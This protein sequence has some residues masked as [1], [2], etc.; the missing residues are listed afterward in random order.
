M[1]Q[2][3]ASLIF[4]DHRTPIIIKHLL[5]YTS[6][7]DNIVQIFCQTSIS[8]L[9]VAS[10]YRKKGELGVQIADPYDETGTI[11]CATYSCLN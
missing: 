8:S 11:I 6:I 10:I 5:F 7:K 1:K 4:K 2:E 3:K 9:D